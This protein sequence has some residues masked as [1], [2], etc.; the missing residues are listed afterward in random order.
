MSGFTY[1]AKRKTALAKNFL[2]QFGPFAED[3]FLVAVSKIMAQRQKIAVRKRSWSQGQAL[4]LLKEIALND[5]SLLTKRYNWSGESQWLDLIP[6]LI[7][8]L[9]PTLSMF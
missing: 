8:Q 1:D 4:Q 6:R 3:K 2:S 5:A 9:S 7:C